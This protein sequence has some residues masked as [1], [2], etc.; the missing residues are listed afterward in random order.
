MCELLSGTFLQGAAGLSTG[1]LYVP[2]NSSGTEELLML[3]KVL[4]KY[5][6]PYTTHLR[7]EGASLCEAVNEAIAQIKSSTYALTSKQINAG[8]IGTWTINAP[9]GA[10]RIVAIT[11]NVISPTTWGN[12]VPMVLSGL[13]ISGT[14][15]ELS[16]RAYAS[17]TYTPKIT[18]VYI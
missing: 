12:A 13:S 3:M 7:S 10:T 2:G 6:L 1:L 17:D 5:F 4:K 18:M 16:V 8:A 11:I 14:S 9:A 15:A